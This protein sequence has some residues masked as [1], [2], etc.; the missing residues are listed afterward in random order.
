MVIVVRCVL[1]NAKIIHRADL[2]LNGHLAM[3]K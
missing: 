3:L 2:S 1:A